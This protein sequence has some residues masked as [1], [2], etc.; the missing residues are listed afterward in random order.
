[1]KMARAL[2]LRAG[3]VL[4]AAT[5]EKRV[6][7]QYALAVVSMRDFLHEAL[8]PYEQDEVTRLITDTHDAAVLVPVGHCTVG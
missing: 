4:A 3:D 1:M 8:V 6:A 7:T 5:Y 2:P